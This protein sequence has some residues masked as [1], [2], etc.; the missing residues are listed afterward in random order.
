[1][2]DIYALNVYTGRETYTANRPAKTVYSRGERGEDVEGG[3]LWSPVRSPFYIHLI[4]L[5]LFISSIEPLRIVHQLYLARNI[6][7]YRPQ[8]L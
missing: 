7:Y 6:C 2:P 8:L 3:P 1:M 4:L 5:E